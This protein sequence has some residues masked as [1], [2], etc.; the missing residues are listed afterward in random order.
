MKAATK[1]EN[2]VREQEICIS[3]VSGMVSREHQ[4]HTRNH[5]LAK[6]LYNLNFY[7]VQHRKAIKVKKALN[8]CLVPSVEG[9]I[10]KI[11]I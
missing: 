7:E 2:F 6:L 1:S 11:A 5:K 3:N 8:I 4:Q 9:R 10:F